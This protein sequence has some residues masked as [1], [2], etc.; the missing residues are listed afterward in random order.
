MHSTHSMSKAQSPEGREPTRVIET[1]LRA[2]E[3]L[4]G[5]APQVEALEEQVAAREAAVLGRILALMQPVFPRLAQPIV[6]VEPWHED[7]R[8]GAP[9]REP[10]IL[11]TRSFQGSRDEATGDNLHVQHGLVLLDRGRLLEFDATARWTNGAGKDASW[12]VQAVEVP[13][14]TEFASKHLRAILAGVLDALREALAREHEEKRDLKE[15]LAR[16]AEAERALD[17]PRT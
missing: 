1:F 3:K 11:L 7:K 4:S 6:L 13:I 12:S 16:L 9:L 5:L 8:K 10:G 15:R 14:T 2:L 17:G